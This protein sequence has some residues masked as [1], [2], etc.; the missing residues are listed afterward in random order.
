MKTITLSNGLL[1]KVDDE[2]YERLNQHKWYPSGGY[3]I[4]QTSSMKSISMA[5][6]VIGPAPYEMEIHHKDGDKLNNQSGNLEHVKYYVHRQT[7]SG[8]TGYLGVYRHGDSSFRAQIK[9][10]GVIYRIGKFKDQESAARARDK[11]ALELFGPDV[12]LNF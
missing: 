9:K 6:A 12:T 2:D 1:A 3:A 10:D 5:E 8:L 11:M 4:R 7:R